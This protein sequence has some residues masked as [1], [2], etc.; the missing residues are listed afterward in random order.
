MTTQQAVFLHNH[1]FDLYLPASDIQAKVAEMG[2]RI[3]ADFEDK[4]PLFLIV[5]N[6]AFIFAA[7]LV[8]A[9]QIESELAFIKLS[10]YSGLSTSGKVQTV[11]GLN[12]PLEGRHVIVVEDIID[13]GKTMQALVPDL[14]RQN[15]GSV[16]IAALLLKPECLAHP[17]HIEYLGFEIP[18]KFVVGYGL[19]YDGLGRGWASIYQIRK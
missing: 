5:L 14:Q 1:W 17:L 3:R 10:S 6:G 7:D 15:P 12:V 8:R 2:Q 18:N 19:D 4:R 16:S 9:C 13:S 11:M